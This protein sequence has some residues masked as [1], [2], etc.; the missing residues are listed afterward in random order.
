MPLA[1]DVL[2]VKHRGTSPVGQQGL[3]LDGPAARRDGYGTVEVMELPD[4]NVEL[5]DIFDAD[6][7]DRHARDHGRMLVEDPKRRARV[8]QLHAAGAIRT[9]TDHYRAAMVLQHG[10][11]L[12]NYRLARELATGAA[13][14]GHPRGR[15]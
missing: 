9:A 15:W 12:D 13:Q 1:R 3:G 2:P 8:L 4:D 11:E 7:R 6:Q 10:H 5:G 14:L